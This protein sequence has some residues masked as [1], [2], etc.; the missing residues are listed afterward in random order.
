MEIKQKIVPD[1]DQEEKTLLDEDHQIIRLVLNG[2]TNQYRKLV[3]KYQN[4]VFNLFLRM[5]KNEGQAKEYTQQ[6]FVKAYEALNKF[7]FEHRF[8]SWIY[9]IAINLA[10]SSLKQQR[11]YAGMQ[12]MNEVVVTEKY[13]DDKNEVLRKV[14]NMLNEKQRVVID[15]KYFSGLSYKEIAETLQ[16]PEKR[17]KSRL[18]DARVRIKELLE[19]ADYFNR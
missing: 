3:E 1:R 11:K 14:L 13:P 5:L 16:L 8:F 4:P 9:R 10:L 17:V 19:K 12:S 2:E 7:R 15:L 18:Y 6:T